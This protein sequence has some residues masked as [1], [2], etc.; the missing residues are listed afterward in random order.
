MYADDN[1]Q[2]APTCGRSF[3]RPALVRQVHDAKP[4]GRGP[5]HRREKVGHDETREEDRYVFVQDSEHALKKF[6][7]RN[8][9]TKLS[10]HATSPRQQGRGSLAR[11]PVVEL[12][13]V[14][15]NQ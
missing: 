5:D 12:Q 3:M 15:V 11:S 14:P 4:P 10:A 1:R 7:E 6:R 13:V 9:R 2:A 8:L